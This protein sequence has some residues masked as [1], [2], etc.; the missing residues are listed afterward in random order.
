MTMKVPTGAWQRDWIQR[1]G[2]ALDRAITVRY[3]Q[4]PSVFGDLRIPAGRPALSGAASFAE[5][6]DDQLAALATQNGFAGVTTIAGASSKWHVSRFHQE[7]A[8]LGYGAVLSRIGR[9]ESP[10]S[11][12]IVTSR[13]AHSSDS[14][15]T[16]SSDRS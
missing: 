3:V 10:M 9:Y 7:P 14:S 4:T 11:S 13:E 15:T 2:G 16:T 1:H 12:P 5:L 6:D 8:S